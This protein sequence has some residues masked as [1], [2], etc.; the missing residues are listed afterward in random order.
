MI[1][2]APMC[3]RC[4]QPPAAAR[5]ALPCRAGEPHSPTRQ[6]NRPARSRS[7]RPVPPRSSRATPCP[8]SAAASA[9]TRT[10]WRRAALPRQAKSPAARWAGRTALGRRH[11][12][13]R[14]HRDSGGRLY[15]HQ[16]RE[17]AQQPFAHADVG[18]L[19]IDRHAPARRD[20]GTNCIGH[21][22]HFSVVRRRRNAAARA[23]SVQRSPSGKCHS[24]FC[25][26]RSA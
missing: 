5:R 13:T 7:S 10:A 12:E 15:R 4:A 9:R 19:M 21:R 23:S 18:S 20:R 1:G 2:S 17:T 22:V 14:A 3:R 25:G 26:P 24:P 11:R 16:R 6:H 8:A